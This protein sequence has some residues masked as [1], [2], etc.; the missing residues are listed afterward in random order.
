[1]VFRKLCESHGERIFLP[2]ICL[3]FRTNL[4]SIDSLQAAEMGIV[5]TFARQTLG[6]AQRLVFSVQASPLDCPDRSG[7]FDPALPAK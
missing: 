2:V 1:M 5:M 4:A 3:I 7:G 6:M